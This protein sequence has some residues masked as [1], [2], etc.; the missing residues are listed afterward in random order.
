[1]AV[2]MIRC[3]GCHEIECNCPRLWVR[4]GDAGEYESFGEDLLALC[5]YLND[6]RAGRITGWVDHGAG[7]GIETANYWGNDFISLFWGD[8]NANLLRPLTRGERAVVEAS[9]EEV[10]I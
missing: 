8:A 2:K 10:F 1:M 6:C 9:L 5:E 3:R 7:V 4:V